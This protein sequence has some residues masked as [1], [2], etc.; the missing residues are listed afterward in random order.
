MNCPLVIKFLACFITCCITYF[1]LSYVTLPIL[2]LFSLSYCIICCIDHVYSSIN[3]M[4]KLYLTPLVP[5]RWDHPFTF[6]LLLLLLVMKN[7]HLIK[8]KFVKGTTHFTADWVE[9]AKPGI[10]LLSNR[11]IKIPLLLAILVQV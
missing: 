5:V 4:I 8:K 9:A 3:I 2:Y 7:N 1:V 10:G 11:G 6:K